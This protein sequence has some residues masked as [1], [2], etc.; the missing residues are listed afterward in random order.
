MYKRQLGQVFT[1][2]VIEQLSLLPVAEGFATD[3]RQ[4]EKQLEA[5]SDANL[6]TERA[7][8]ELAGMET[9]I[10]MRFAAVKP[11]L[12]DSL[13]L[14]FEAAARPLLR[15][16]RIL[17]ARLAELQEQLLQALQA[18]DVAALALAQ[19]TQAARTQLTR[20][21]FW[22][23]A[24]PSLQTIDELAPSWA[25]MSSAAKWRAAAAAL[26]EA[27][28]DSTRAISWRS[29]ALPSIWQREAYSGWRR[30]TPASRCCSLAS[31]SSDRAGCAWKEGTASGSLTIHRNSCSTWSMLTSE[32]ASMR[33]SSIGS[34]RACARGAT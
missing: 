8:D 33:R 26:G 1:Q 29:A 18:S 28:Y 3:R 9:L 32:G 30:F 17:L 16:R 13:W 15:E 14:P 24:R 23:P 7:L 21:L 31:G 22:V 6:R 34:G 11:R 5:A 27:G 19:R 4:R 12:P 2:T 20:L 25:W 10:V